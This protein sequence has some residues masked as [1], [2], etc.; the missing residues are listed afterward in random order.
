VSNWIPGE[1]KTLVEEGGTIHIRLSLL[2]THVGR[3]LKLAF[4]SPDL[5]RLILEGRQ[6]P[7]LRL[8]QLLDANL[9]LAW[10][11]QPAFLETLAEAG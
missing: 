2:R 6:P 10:D 3:M 11:H 4:H 9:P 5:I 8:A 7:G 1:E